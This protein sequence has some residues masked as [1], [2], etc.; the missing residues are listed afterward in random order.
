MLRV[1]SLQK[2][3]VVA[4][5]NLARYWGGGQ[6]FVTYFKGV[7]D[8]WQ[9]C[10]TGEEGQKC[11]ILRDILYGRPLLQQWL[12]NLLV[13]ISCTICFVIFYIQSSALRTGTV[14]HATSMMH[15]TSRDSLSQKKDVGFNCAY[16]RAIWY[17]FMMTKSVLIRTDKRIL[18]SESTCAFASRCSC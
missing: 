10:M 8:L 2:V 5:R 1:H 17:Q 7:R 6:K 11:Q 4:F 9:L 14:D 16:V 13:D 12:D 18:N 3:K 15:L